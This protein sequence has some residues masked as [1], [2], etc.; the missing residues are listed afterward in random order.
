MSRAFVLVLDSLGIGSTP[1]ADA[2]GD[3]GADTLGHIAAWANDAGRPLRLPALERLGLGAAAALAT[4]RWPD[5]LAQRSGFEAVFA[6]A[7]EASPGK[8]TPSGHWEMAGLPLQRDWHYFP[9]TVPCF[10][11]DFM[12]AWLAACGLGGAL[13]QCHASGTEIIERLGS[14]HVRSG[15]PIVYTSGDSVFQIAA[16]EEHFGLQR[17]YAICAEAFERLRPLQVGRVIARP[18]TGTP[19]QYRRTAQRHDFA[20]EPPGRTLLDVAHA[21]GR[22]V[23]A[24]G[25]IADI[26]AHRGPTCSVKA[27][28][29][30]ALFDATL[31][32]VEQAPEGALVMVNFVDFDQEFG[33]RRDVCGYADALQAFDRRLPELHA[34]LRSG[35]LVVITADHGC[36]PTWPGSDH[37]REHVP[38]LFFGPGIPGRSAGVRRHFCDLGQTVAAH[39]GL[40]PLAHGVVV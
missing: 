38:Q 2:R 8:D 22:T 31:Q 13:G 4:G 27:A 16:H 25:K 24:V 12:Q 28:G 40:P 26:F 1:D 36:D 29:N 15:W 34:R 5:G 11:A 6:A 35:D 10:P 32:Q 33:H 17:L 30:E 18:F 20:V 19:G 23:A 7:R 39:L 9:R 37:T 14:E 21:A 3:A